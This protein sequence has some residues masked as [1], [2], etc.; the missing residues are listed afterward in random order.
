MVIDRQPQRAVVAKIPNTATTIDDIAVSRANWLDIK[1]PREEIRWESWCNAI[2]A[3]V[4][5]MLA[6]LSGFGGYEITK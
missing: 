2:H 3:N 1:K 6:E 4:L 5:R